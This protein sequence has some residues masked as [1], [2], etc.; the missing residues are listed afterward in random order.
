MLNKSRTG[1]AGVLLILL[2]SM[3]HL[4]TSQTQ[5]DRFYLPQPKQP[6]EGKVETR[7][8]TL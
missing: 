5:E 3:P 6:F 2:V 1:I 4:A 8:G 7:I